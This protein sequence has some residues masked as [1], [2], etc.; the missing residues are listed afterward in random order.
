MNVCVLLDFSSRDIDCASDEFREFF[1]GAYPDLP[2]PSRVVVVCADDH[3]VERTKARS[4]HKAA[5]LAT[6][7]DAEALAESLI[8]HTLVD[9]IGADSI[10]PEMLEAF[11]AACR[12]RG[13]N[14]AA[15][16]RQAAPARLARTV[17]EIA[18][19]GKHYGKTL[20]ADALLRQATQ[21]GVEGCILSIERSPASIDGEDN[22][23]SDFVR[24]RRRGAQA[25]HVQRYGNLSPHAARIDLSTVAGEALPDL[26]II[27][28]SGGSHAQLACDLAI[29]LEQPNPELAAI[30]GAHIVVR[31]QFDD[32]PLADNHYRTSLRR[33]SALRP[34]GAEY[35]AVAL[36][37]QRGLSAS[38]AEALFP[39]LQLVLVTSDAQHAVEAAQESGARILV[40]D[41]YAPAKYEDVFAEIEPLIIQTLELRIDALERLFALERA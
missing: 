13:L 20:V 7:S 23:R 4:A 12:A 34:A 18:A 9:F 5:R 27:D 6:T 11:R 10:T 14:Y 2:A 29:F 25:L 38:A 19:P 1:A 30:S 21:R 37:L 22:P 33:T 35:K 36:L 31:P 39:D 24:L 26:V 41:D 3:E 40:T 8:G 17:I 16:V 15:P 32:G 28:N